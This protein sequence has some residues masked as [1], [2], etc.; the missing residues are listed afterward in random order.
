MSEQLKNIRAA[1]LV[2]LDP[3]H[4]ALR[5]QL[6]DVARLS[7]QRDEALHLLEAAEQV[8]LFKFSHICEMP[9]TLVITA[10]GPFPPC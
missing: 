2:L 5:T 6:G 10:S 8:H 9:N 7:Q 1:Y 4:L 3:V